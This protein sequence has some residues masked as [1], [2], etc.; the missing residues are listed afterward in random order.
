MQS[1]QEKERVFIEWLTNYAPKDLIHSES[2]EILIADYLR[3]HFASVVSVTNLNAAVANI[4]NLERL[5]QKS[6]QELAV[7]VLKAQR[8][9][10]EEDA[11]RGEA[12]MRKDYLDSLESH[13][14]LEERPGKKKELDDQAEVAKI[15]KEIDSYI[16]RYTCNNPS[17]LGM[18]FPR[19]EARQKEMRKIKA[20]FGNTI[21]E[22]EAALKAVKQ[23]Y[24]SY[25]S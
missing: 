2:N 14:P 19:T 25:Q 18:D 6:A 23:Q 4:P 7:E 16:N 8:K 5:P 22:R 9:K 3:L 10:E 24:F 21:K 12:K 17:G 11:K 20:G 1:H 13:K 15:N